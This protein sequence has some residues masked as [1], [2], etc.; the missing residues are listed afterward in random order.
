[1]TESSLTPFRVDIRPRRAW[2]QMAWNSTRPLVHRFLGFDRLNHI[3]RDIL[4]LDPSRPFVD[5]ALDILGVEYDASRQ[6]L[7]AI[8]TSGPLVAF[9]NHPFGGLEGLILT[10][11]LLRVRPD[12]KLMAN[13]LLGRLPE[14]RDSQIH[15]DPFGGQKA[16][17][18]NR[19]GLRE[20]IRWVREGGAL[21]VF[22]A[23]VVSHYSWKDN[24]VTDP[25]W[26]STIARI[27]R[28]TGASALPVYFEGQNSSL[29]QAMGMLHPRL[30]TVMLGREL[31]GKQRHRIQL[32]VGNAI[33]HKDLATYDSPEE[34][35][36]YL[37][38]RTYLLKSHSLSSPPPQRSRRLPT[39][40]RVPIVE[41]EPPEILERELARLPDDHH[42][43]RSREFD[44]FVSRSLRIP[45]ILHEIGRLR[46][47]TFRAIGGGT[48]NTID[49]DRFDERYHHLFVWDRKHSRLVGSYRMGLTDELRRD[50]PTRH[51]YTAT[52]FRIQPRLFDEMGPT[53]ELGRSFVRQEYQKS[54]SSL[55]LLWKGIARFV[56]R[57]PRYRKLIG[58]VTI[59]NHYHCVTQ[60][61][62]IAFLKT[63]DRRSELQSLVSGRHPPRRLRRLQHE[64]R[65]VSRVV[66]EIREVDNLVRE[67][68]S[69]QKSIPV[70]LRQYLKFDAKLLGFTIDPN[71]SE[72]LDALMLVDLPSADPS[73]LARYF[74]RE[75][76]ASYLRYHG[77]SG[78]TSNAERVPDLVAS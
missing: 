45:H 46:E 60:D 26:S 39:G 20:A 67:I 56:A 11:L 36:D 9:A 8:P 5:R 3:Y 74:E 40:R 13:Y 33:A 7:D 41:A 6:E 53:I 64:H 15:V 35:I 21:A 31:L 63:Q 78:V 55:L 77:V 43:L 49:L 52:L 37:R 30:R 58:P 44:V 2:Q 51:L 34:L 76:L 18:T 16:N 57:H 25:P 72:A 54:Y 47:V 1:M 61:L 50:H 4:S 14:L 19:R 65:L 17:E 29:F 23:G 59:S 28:T 42:L 75:E 22:P 38:L 12:V 32:R 62:L 70:L 24:S 27:I 48:G 66:R 73:V 68:E 69:D 10:S 71:F